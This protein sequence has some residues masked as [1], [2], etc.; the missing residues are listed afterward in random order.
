PC[1][2]GE[3]VGLS[4]ERFFKRYGPSRLPLAGVRRIPYLRQQGSEAIDSAGA[5]V[6][7]EG[8]AQGLALRF[9]CAQQQG[10]PVGLL[11]GDCHGCQPFEAPRRAAPVPQRCSHAQALQEQGVRRR[12]FI[13][14]QRRE[15][16]AVKR[17]S[18]T[19][20]VAQLAPELEAF[21]EEAARCRELAPPEGRCAEPPE[22]RGDATPVLSPH[23]DQEGGLVQV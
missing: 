15:A 11:R 19:V 23:P 16:E 13:S 8:Q 3:C 20:L 9:R 21:L 14:H 12:P 4:R 10:G 17:G 1:T 18:Y 22:G 5:L 7:R 6:S 2:L